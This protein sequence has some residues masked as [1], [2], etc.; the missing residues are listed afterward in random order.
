MQQLSACEVLVDCRLDLSEGPA[1]HAA[2]GAL[3]WV[4]ILDGVVHRYHLSSGEHRTWEVGQMVGA[5]VVRESGGMMLA[6]RDGFATLDTVS[7]MT[8]LVAEVESTDRGQRMND[9]K[10]DARGRFWAG[11]MSASTPVPGSGT[12]YR[13]DADRTVTP[14]LG[15]VTIS[16]GL[17]WSPDNRTMYFIDTPTGRVD[18]FDFDL[19]SGTIDNRRGCAQV[20]QGE[21]SPDGMAV[22]AEGCLWVA[23]WGVGE[24][25]RYSPDG[26]HCATLRTP[27]PAPSS[28]AF[29][30]SGLDTLMITTARLGLTP[31]QCAEFPH[32]GS[33]LAADVG[34]VGL[35]VATC[36]A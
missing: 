11:T 10:C 18:A 13:L 20:T 31:E 23:V 2:E 30:G 32:S 25:R 17:G 22:D 27:L 28:C 9:G 16:N 29:G 15:G 3:Y 35:P 1:W 34:V 14:M 8:T 12:L 26:R 24:V 6:I 7:G 19:A 33:I 5:V 36:A 21:A 4:S